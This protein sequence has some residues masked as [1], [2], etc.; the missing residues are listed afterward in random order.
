MRIGLSIISIFCLLLFITPVRAQELYLLAPLESTPIDTVANGDLN[1]R[2]QNV[3]FFKNNEYFGEYAEGYTLPGYWFRPTLVYQVCREVRLEAG[4]QMLQYGGTNRADKVYPIVNIQWQMN[5]RFN[6]HIGIIDGSVHHRTHEAILDEE[7]A[8]TGRP[9][10]GVR[11]RT[12]Q[13]GIL[14]GE[15]WLDWQAF[16]KRGDTIPERF[17]AGI[18]VDYKPLYNKS[19]RWQLHMPFRVTFSHIGG[20]ISDFEE[21]M[22]SLMNMQIGAEAKRVVTR[23]FLKSFSVG[24]D[25]LFFDAMTGGDVRPFSSGWALEPDINV[26]MQHLVLD[27]AYWHSKDYFALHGMPLLMSLSNYQNLYTPERNILKI[28]LGLQH[29]I[30]KAVRFSLN[31]KAYHDVDVSQFDYSYGFGISLTPNIRICKVRY[32]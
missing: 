23:R 21:P 17:M 10:T 16:I 2:I 14:S 9:E 31:F 13:D 12:T 22:Q 25:Y 24:V 32:S 15:V 6:L 18:R 29:S 8:F 28:H 27:I 19:E 7:R 5:K 11:L 20:Q 3:S 4:L 26:T 1:L 30:S